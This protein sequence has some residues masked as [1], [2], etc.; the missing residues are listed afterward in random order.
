[1]K[2]SDASTELTGVFA[3]RYTILRELG[4]GATAFVYL[5]TD[6][7][8]GHSVAIK[9]LRPEFAESLGADRFLKEIRLGKT[10]LH[11]HILPV[12]DSGTV[13]KQLY[14]VLPAAD[15]GTLRMRL[16]R[17][18]QLP[19]EEVVAI[20]RTVATAL[21]HAHEKGLIHRDVKPEN[22][23]FASGQ[24]CLGDFGIA[25]ALERAMGD[26]TTSES[27]VRGTPAYMSPEQAS[28]DQALDGRSDIYSLA[29]VVYEMLAGIQAFVGPTPQSIIAQRFLH[30]PRPVRV[31]RA[32]LPRAVEAVVS[33]ALS[34]SPADRFQTATG[35]ADALEV[36]ARTP[37]ESVLSGMARRRLAIVSAVGVLAAAAIF[38]VVWT[39]NGEK[40]QA[41]ALVDDERRIAVLYLDDLT[42]NTVPAYVADGLTEDLIDQL[43]G[44]RALNVISSY[45][46][47]PYRARA[48]ALDSIA[49]ALNVGRIITGSVA[50]SGNTMRLN[51]RLVDAHTGQQLASWPLERQ[52]TDLFTLQTKL[53]DTIAYALRTEIGGQIKGRELRAS[54]KSLAAWEAAQRAHAEMVRAVEAGQRADPRHEQLM[55]QA[56]SSYVRTAKLDPSW[57]HP[58]IKRGDIA[59]SM[60]VFAT[61]PPNP[62]DSIGFRSLPR[63][64]QREIW[65]R[66]AF[67]LAEDALRLSPRSAQAFALR[68]KARVNLMEL[69]LPGS[70][71]L[72]SLAERDLRAALDIRPD[73]ASAWVT[74]AHL[75]LTQSRFA[76]AAAA[77]QRA[78]DAD[79]FFEL[80]DVISSALFTSL[81]SEHFTDARRWCRMAL[82]RYPRDSRFT[83]CELTVLGWTG[84]TRADVAIAHRTLSEIE[85]R[86]SLQLLW[87][88]WGYRRVMIAAVLARSGMDDSARALLAVLHSKQTPDSLVGNIAL[89]ESYVRI[90]LN[91][92]DGSLAELT[93]YLRSTPQ[94][95]SQIATHPWF[96]AL[97]GD[98]RFAALVQ[99][100]H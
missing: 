55:F 25:R 59:T 89:G 81:Y 12:L 15:G 30:A 92:R 86:D 4:R 80:R 10:L 8:R 37:D 93:T 40:A 29:C 11:P 31:F 28:A 77:A 71:S 54:T 32:G 94:M 14:F 21:T 35:F 69:G 20:T 83:E 82:D 38:A 41:G 88:T 26:T 57:A 48:V 98:A 63:P 67:T 76:D 5:A 27:I 47:K 3:G 17:D 99:Q 90:L 13:G 66:R 39:K 52:W 58:V 61:R 34:L 74:L 75:L 19:L 51:V 62:A 79:P 70:D 46:V 2:L 65:H 87:D 100:P 91:D 78:Y 50:R 72:A 1:M 68:G 97:R 33:R 18:K 42:P 43:S 45:G 60:A 84:Q 73:L 49:R 96:R 24:A 85:R 22:I 7:Q 56:D 36:A 95:R 16:A 64:K 9:V 6:Q 44:V 53:A 23:L